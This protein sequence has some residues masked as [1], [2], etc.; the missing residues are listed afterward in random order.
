MSGMN[1]RR[2]VVEG[3]GCVME[4]FRYRGCGAFGSVVS[5]TGV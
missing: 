2:G 4:E 5:G 1:G 3:C